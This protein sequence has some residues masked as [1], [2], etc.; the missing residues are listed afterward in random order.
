MRRNP[1][2][3]RLLLPMR[4]NAFAA[5]ALALLIGACTTGSLDELS[6]GGSGGKKS[7]GGG[8]GGSG[9]I[10]VDAGPDG[11]LTTGGN[12]GTGGGDGSSP[13]KSSCMDMMLGASETGLDCGGT[14]CPKCGVEQGCKLASDCTSGSCVSGTCKAASCK[15]KAK[16][17]TE[18]DV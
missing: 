10:L 2:R 9:A 12:G 1:N 5:A 16:N 14:S 6:R 15:D 8:K 11:L 18:T 13:T 7:S 17:G 3:G 4:F